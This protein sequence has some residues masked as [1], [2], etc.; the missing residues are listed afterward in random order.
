[1]LVVGMH[2]RNKIDNSEAG[3]NPAVFCLAGAKFFIDWRI[4][5]RASG[6]IQLVCA[7]LF[8][9]FHNFC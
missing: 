3:L 4:K 1:M 2:S 8:F 9:K 6:G 5:C 7:S